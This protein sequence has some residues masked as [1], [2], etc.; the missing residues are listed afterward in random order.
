MSITCPSCHFI[1]LDGE[2]VDVP[3]W[4]CPNCEIVYEKFLK[5]HSETKSPVSVRPLKPVTLIPNQEHSLKNEPQ[6]QSTVSQKNSQSHKFSKSK[7]VQFIKRYD[8]GHFITA[9][10]FLIMLI[11]FLAGFFLG[12]EYF[13]YELRQAVGSAFSGVSDRMKMG[14][15]LENND[16]QYN[17]VQAGGLFPKTKELPAF[18]IK[19]GFREFDSNIGNKA[20]TMTIQITNS[21]DKKI[22]GFNGILVFSDILGNEIKSLKLAMTDGIE[23]GS[24]I[25]WSAEMDY[26]QFIDSD[27]AL[28]NAKQ[29][30]V[31]VNLKLKKVI[32]ADG[33]IESF[34]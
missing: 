29:E 20:V 28:L 18:L 25:N 11:V 33:T 13:K 24:Y 27:R 31:K 15:T 1:R 10:G 22:N 30:K 26:N 7:A 23:A 34:E 3:D 21:F 5:N 2:H 12:R 4:K 17:G 9:K 8:L 19:K 32:F 14:F 16:L 6:Q